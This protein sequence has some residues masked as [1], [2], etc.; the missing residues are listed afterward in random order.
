MDQKDRRLHKRISL[1]IPVSCS[2]IDDE[3][4][5]LNFNMGVIKDI[6]QGGAGLE[7][8]NKVASNLMVLSFFDFKN[9]NHEIKVEVIH[10]RPIS[11]GRYSVGVR[12]IDSKDKTYDFI[13]FIVK[14]S[15]LITSKKA[16]CKIP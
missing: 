2:S 3:N 12:F 4:R 14:Y 15:S 6:S 7:I 10:E 11:K 5:L 9:I 8:L 16:V 13:Y 1:S